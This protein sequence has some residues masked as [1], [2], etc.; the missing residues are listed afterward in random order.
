[1]PTYD[2]DPR[3]WRDWQRLTPAQQA[4]FLDAVHQML[5]DFRAKRPF[6]ASLRVKGYQSC[7]GVFD[8]TW[9]DDG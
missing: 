7:A 4:M 8:M 9:A 6:L 2:V 3:F 5:A 1:M